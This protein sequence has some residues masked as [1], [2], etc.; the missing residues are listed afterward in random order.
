MSET[1]SLHETAARVAELLEQRGTKIVFAES[2]TGGLVAATL[3]RIPGIS[4]FLCGSAVVYQNATKHGWLSISEDLLADPGPVSRECATAMAL[5]VLQATPHADVA[6]SVTGHLGPD[7]PAEQDGLIY[8]GFARRLGGGETTAVVA[9]HRLPAQASSGAEIRIER[10][11]A[12]A[13]LVLEAACNAL[14]S[15]DAAADE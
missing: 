6:L 8:I 5:N 2:C 1:Q 13:I 15:R 12:A 7:A 9:E 10:Q 4:R 3:A 14:R 11:R